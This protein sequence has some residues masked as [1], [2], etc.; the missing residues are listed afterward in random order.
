MCNQVDPHYL[1]NSKNTTHRENLENTKL[2]SRDT[3]NSSVKLAQIDK[4]WRYFA[5]VAKSWVPYK[6]H[7][8]SLKVTQAYEQGEDTGMTCMEL[9]GGASVMHLLWAE[10]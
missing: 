4:T 7:L 6:V 9:V 5:T 1:F 2:S 10:F 3:T 8:H